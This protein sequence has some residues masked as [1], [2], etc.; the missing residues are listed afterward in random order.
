MDCSGELLL[1]NRICLDILE[2][3]VLKELR[4]IFRL[5][6]QIDTLVV[7]SS[8]GHLSVQDKHVLLSLAL[9]G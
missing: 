5:F 7:C 4:D 2:G 8:L 1:A 3:V 9:G 6:R